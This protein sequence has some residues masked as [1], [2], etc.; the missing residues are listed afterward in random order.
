V[1]A[2]SAAAVFDAPEL[3]H[4]LGDRLVLPGA[5]NYAKARAIFNSAID[6]RPAAVAY[7]RFEED[8]CLVVDAARKCG[9]NVV[10]RSAG[11]SVSGRC[12]ANDAVVVDVSGMNGVAVDR[13]GIVVGG[14]A[15]WSQL[16][17]VSAAAGVAVTGGTVSTTGVAGLTLGGGIGWLL[18][19]F[20][21]ASDSLIGARLV[22]ADGK[23]MEANDA[24]DP[25]VMW[26]L[27][28]SGRSLGVVTELRFEPH[29]IR[30]LYAGSF[31]VALDRVERWAGPIADLM[32]EPFPS[33]ML[34]PSFLFRDG[35]AVLSLDLAMH[36]PSPAQR[37]AIDALRGL[38][39]IVGDTVR[40]RSYVS[41]QTMIDEPNRSGLR[42]Y[43]MAAY[44]STVPPE[45]V[46]A[47]AGQFSRSPSQD[48][49]L[50]LETLHGAFTRPRLPSSFPSRE[51]RFSALVVGA[52]R[53]AADDRRNRAWIES[54]RESLSPYL[55]TQ[56]PYS[57]YS[58]DAVPEQGDGNSRLT[59]IKV[60][61]DRDRLFL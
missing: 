1:Y 9:A 50:F 2:Q 45:L 59:A 38:P 13:R 15:T 49:V 21:L 32:T 23:A 8:V 33:L 35:M 22:T 57:N 6:R 41:L 27:R 28:G 25:D 52:W 12:L 48:S 60:R 5:H 18:P 16:D 34:G 58:S 19:S 51:P 10:V 61:L 42:S 37:A 39:G 56:P 3:K 29:P 26:A 17:A 24:D 31:T 44:P 55:S 30:P 54:V 43:W 46:A 40:Q 20:G 14:G 47:L 53:N 7:C 4:R 36:G 11:H